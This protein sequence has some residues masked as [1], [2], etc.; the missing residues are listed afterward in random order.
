MLHGSMSPAMRNDIA[1]AI[2]AV[3]PTDT[4]KRARTAYY[5]VATSPQFQVQR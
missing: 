1:V 3:A 2:A 4:L 5:L